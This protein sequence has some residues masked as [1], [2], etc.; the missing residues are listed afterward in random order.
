MARRSP[1]AGIRWAS[2]VSR[3]ATGRSDA[4]CDVDHDRSRAHR[5]IR[6]RSSAIA[7]P[8]PPNSGPIKLHRVRV[9]SKSTSD[10]RQMDNVGFGVR[11]PPNGVFR[12][13]GARPAR[14]P[15][16]S[17]RARRANAPVAAQPPTRR[18]AHEPA[19]QAKAEAGTRGRLA[20][21]RT[22]GGQAAERPRARA[23]GGRRAQSARRPSPPPARA[24][25]R[26]TP[27][28]PGDAAEA[29]RH[30]GVKPRHERR[31]LRSTQHRRRQ[32]TRPVRPA[33]GVQQSNRQHARRSVQ[34]SCAE[35]RALDVA[36]GDGG[37][38]HS[39]HGSGGGME[40]SATHIFTAWLARAIDLS[41]T[42]YLTVTCL[43]RAFFELRAYS[44][45]VG[46]RR[47]WPHCTGRR[48]TWDGDQNRRSR[49]TGHVE[50]SAAIASRG[51]HVGSTIF[52]F[53]V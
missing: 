21:R 1:S 17:T 28:A 24:Q 5:A 47:S 6:P 2:I 30:A 16:T 44:T 32:S 48:R 11:R 52:G 8:H 3:C 25:W 26:L 31:A 10:S 23:T 37:V 13:A 35:R 38:L 4:P 50:T 51:I 34:P 42:H 40:P 15:T 29:E 18:A 19:A 12:R 20:V 7:V 33:R 53:G 14:R 36:Q 22:R 46:V 43:P 39:A 45:R 49:W 9:A 27:L 41:H